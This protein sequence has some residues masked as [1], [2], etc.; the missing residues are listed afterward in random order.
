[1]K[2]NNLD[3]NFRI[4]YLIRISYLRIVKKKKIYL[5]IS[6]SIMTAFKPIPSLI[7][8]KAIYSVQFYI[9][10]TIKKIMH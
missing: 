9:Y 10:I 1:L 5:R 2:S 4:L 3:F 6:V 7:V 8:I